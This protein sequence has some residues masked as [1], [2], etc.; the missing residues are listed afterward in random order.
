MS[1]WQRNGSSQQIERIIKSII[2]CINEIEN[3]SSNVLVPM[4]QTFASRISTH[5]H[6]L[7]CGV[8]QN[9][10]FYNIK[11]AETHQTADGTVF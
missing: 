8:A 9:K 11:G 2:K 5:K 1:S 7:A 6:I 4:K 3:Q 10:E